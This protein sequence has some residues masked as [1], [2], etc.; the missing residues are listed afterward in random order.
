MYLFKD[1][2][3]ILG[4]TSRF[5]YSSFLITAVLL[6]M[7]LI[8]V[9]TAGVDSKKPDN[10]NNAYRLGAIFTAFMVVGLVMFFANLGTSLA[11]NNYKTDKNLTA[12]QKD[13][14]E[15]V[16]LLNKYKIDVEEAEINPILEMEDKN[17]LK[18]SE[19]KYLSVSEETSGGKSSTS[20]YKVL[21]NGKL[22]ELSNSQQ[23]E[24]FFKTKD[25]TG[26]LGTS[27]LLL[28]KSLHKHYHLMLFVASLIIVMFTLI[29]AGLLLNSIITGKKDIKYIIKKV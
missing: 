17:K 19:I 14:S 20:M 13:F 2:G 1:F 7:V 10:V 4:V 22:E 26:E 29:N 23:K 27:D 3:D 16:T 21:G 28:D 15:N 24:V 25:H 5:N 6:L 9:I 12:L 18:G 8:I 11:P